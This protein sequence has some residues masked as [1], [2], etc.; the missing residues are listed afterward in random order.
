[1]LKRK[2][3]RA[4][5]ILAGSGLAL[6]LVNLLLGEVVFFASESS[7]GWMASCG[8]A[9]M[10]LGGFCHLF[11]SSCP[12]C[13]GPGPRPRWSYWDDEYCSH[14]GKVYP[15]DDRPGGP[16]KENPEAKAPLF[17]D[18]K[19]ARRAMF[20]LAAGGLCLAAAAMIPTRFPH[21]RIWGPDE[22]LRYAKLLLALAGA[23]LLTAAW[24]LC[25]RKLRCPA[26]SKGGVPPW[27]K[28]GTV[29]YCRSCG[30]ALSFAADRRTTGGQHRPRGKA[31]KTYLRQH[32]TV[33]RRGLLLLAAVWC[34]WY[35]RP[36]DIYDL[37][38]GE[39]PAY[40]SV[41]VW[42]Q[43]DLDHPGNLNLTAGEPEMDSVLE[44]FA[45]LRF[46]RNP[47]EVVLRFFPQGARSRTVEVEKDYQIYLF[48]Y[49]Q[50]ENP[51]LYLNFYITDWHRNFRRELPLYLAQGQEKGRELGAFL[52]ELS[53]SA[54]PDM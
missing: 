21:L 40:L 31:V 13:G 53:R 20:L 45:E 24:R 8:A 29:R 32:Q 5:I 26:C 48:A 23:V 33:I 17:L 34:L 54:A 41:S 50:R 7:I 43:A 22:G 6:L 11:T 25:A 1:M 36:V 15:Y 14:C 19:P 49:D 37:M 3:A 51:I 4:S 44:R 28:P 10:L 16:P 35:A 9:L 12:H 46:H 47:L 39:E 30:A 18:G 38:G 42:R 2:W 27:L 52:L